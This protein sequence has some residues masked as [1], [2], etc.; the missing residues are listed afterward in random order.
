M[1]IRQSII[2]FL[3]LAV[4]F[5]L[6]ACDQQAPA[7]TAWSHADDGVLNAVFSPDGRYLLTAATEQVA[8]LWEVSTT[9]RR[10]QWQN[11]SESQAVESPLAFSPDGLFAAT[12][13]RRTI[14][15]WRV[16]DGRPLHRLT[17]PQNVKAM[18]LSPAASHALIVMADGKATYFDIENRRSI[19][20]FRHDG[21][22]VNSPVDHPINAVDISAD[23]RFA[24]T[25]GDDHTA[26]LW[27]LQTGEE[28]HQFIHDNLVNLVRFNDAQQYIVTAAD[29][30]QTYVHDAQTYATRYRL[31]SDLLP[32]G[33]EL[34]D[35]PVFR[36]TTTAVAFSPDNRLLATGHPNEEICLWNLESGLKDRCWKVPRLSELRPGVVVHALAFSPDSRQLISAA[37][38]GQTHLWELN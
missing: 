35:L 1:T 26:R 12:S 29:N 4:F 36:T 28:R 13:E 20:R 22:Q 5:C 33:Y 11:D 37:T 6:A 15:I 10:Y 27:D 25:G 16:S 38:N 8:G 34:P 32:I 30:G 21:S 7:Y 23:G 17:L 19:Y 24:L 2:R 3:M 31:K 14:I 9:E 18:A